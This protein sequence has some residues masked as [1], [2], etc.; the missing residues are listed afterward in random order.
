[1]PINFPEGFSIKKKVI[2]IILTPTTD[3]LQMICQRKMGVSAPQTSSYAATK[4]LV[5]NEIE[6]IEKTIILNVVDKV[7]NLHEKAG[8]NSAR[9]EVKYQTATK[10]IM[11]LKHFLTKK[12]NSRGTQSPHRP[13]KT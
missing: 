5:H 10:E 12:L 1:M 4:F 13:I 2:N 9:I 6:K 7:L 8:E 3:K 11:E